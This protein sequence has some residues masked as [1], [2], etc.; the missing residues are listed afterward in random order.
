MGSGDNAVTPRS[1]KIAFLCQVSDNTLALC[2]HAADCSRNLT[3]M[4]PDY[5][6][7]FLCFTLRPLPCRLLFLRSLSKAQGFSFLSLSAVVLLC[8]F[9]PWSLCRGEGCGKNQRVWGLHIWDRQGQTPSSAFFV[10]A[11]PGWGCAHL[12]SE[13]H[14][15]PVQFHQPPSP[16]QIPSCRKKSRWRHDWWV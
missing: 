1:H 2:P 7:V 3:R 4:D 6:C 12:C 10:P 8:L 15:P 5:I 13:W 9:F 16:K 11:R 14:Y